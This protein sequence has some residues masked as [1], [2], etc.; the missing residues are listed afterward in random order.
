[1]REDDYTGSLL[2]DDDPALVSADVDL[3]EFDA[4]DDAAA[5]A[6]AAAAADEQTLHFGGAA[7]GAKSLADA[8]QLLYDFAD[9]LVE[10]IAEGYELVDDVAN[11]HG[12][13]VQFET[14]DQD[15]GIS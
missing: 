14:D 2:D 10:L 7:N 6:F 4:D 1:M 9:N 11:G 15:D 5:E 13:A 3:Y 8:A 12:T